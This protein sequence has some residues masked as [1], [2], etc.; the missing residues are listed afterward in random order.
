[1]MTIYTKSSEEKPQ[2]TSQPNRQ[3]IIRPLFPENVGSPGS[4]V[5][6]L[7]TAQPLTTERPTTGDDV[8]SLCHSNMRPQD[9]VHDGGQVVS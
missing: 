6:T 8:I 4:T 2:F 1:M 7:R 3:S 9:T 5:Q